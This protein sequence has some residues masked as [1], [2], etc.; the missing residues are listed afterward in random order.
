[1]IW[2]GEQTARKR[3]ARATKSRGCWCCCEELASLRG[4]SEQWGFR[5]VMNPRQRV[6][7]RQGRGSARCSGLCEE[8]VGAAQ[9][10]QPAERV[11]AGVEG[12]QR[13]GE[14]PGIG[15]DVG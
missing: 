9:D 8:P 3:S 15:G 5:E 2:E 7:S 4:G 10:V 1:M 11:A 12:L 6:K 14:L 13:G